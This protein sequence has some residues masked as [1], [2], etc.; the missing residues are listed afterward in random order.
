MEATGRSYGG[1]SAGARAAGRRERL[2]AATITLL[3]TRGEGSTTMTAVCAEAGLTERYF[4][5]SFRS[6]E[7]ALVAALDAVSDEIATMAVAAIEGTSGEAT[8]RVRAAIAGLV[9]WVEA[10]PAKARVALV[11][12]TSH[13]L[14]RE[15]RHALLG[16][17]ADLVA[18]EAETLY[19]DAAWPPGLARVQ[20][21]LY[22]AGLAELVV[23]WMAGE[24]DL[25]AAELT[26]VGTQAFES[27]ARRPS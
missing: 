13:P 6:R 17:F 14:L 18:Q 2:V 22:V 3:A 11:E 10:D 25:D 26:D 9:G 16:V 23:A 12:S 8:D 7:D 27:L 5:E 21:L 4:Y 24:V 1:Q 15:K 19:G 20:G